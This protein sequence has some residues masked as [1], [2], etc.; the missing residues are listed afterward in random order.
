MYLGYNSIISSNSSNVSG[1]EGVSSYRL[2]VILLVNPCKEV[3]A[4]GNLG[5][6]VQIKVKNRGLQLNQNFTYCSF[7]QS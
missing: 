2:L 7:S 4:L 1:S 6:R 3:V 5:M